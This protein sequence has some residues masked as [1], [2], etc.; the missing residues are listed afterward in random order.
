M[1]DDELQLQ[2]PNDR[3]LR[4]TAVRCSMAAGNWRTAPSAAAC[5]AYDELQLHVAAASILQ[6]KASG[7]LQIRMSSPIRPAPGDHDSNRWRPTPC[8][9]GSYQGKFM[10][11]I[12]SVFFLRTPELKRIC[13]TGYNRVS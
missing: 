5:V 10:D 3:R 11:L 9:S 8:T 7:M 13:K 12:S 4:T 2:A 1:A 6:A